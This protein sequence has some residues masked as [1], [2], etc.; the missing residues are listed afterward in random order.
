MNYESLTV[1]LAGF[2]PRRIT[3]TFFDSCKLM[4]IST[5]IIELL[6]NKHQAMPDDRSVINIHLQLDTWFNDIPQELLVW[7]RS[8]SPLPH[9]ITLHIYYWYLIICL[10]QPFYDQSSTTEGDGKA[11]SGSRRNTS[12]KASG[13]MHDRGVKMVDRA[14]HKIVQLLQMFEEQHSMTFFPRNM[15]HVIYECGIVLLKEAVMAPLTA[16][17]KRAT[18]LQAVS[19]CLRALRRTSKTW[20]WAE[21]LANQLEEDLNK[22][23]ANDTAQPFIPGENDQTGQTPYPPVQVWDPTGPGSSFEGGFMQHFSGMQIHPPGGVPSTSQLGLDL[24]L[25]QRHG[26]S[27]PATLD[28]LGGVGER[29]DIVNTEAGAHDAIPFAGTPSGSTAPYSLA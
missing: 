22:I 26:L 18:V 23:R 10:Y 17:K 12:G 27:D 11:D 20:P 15:I 7:A 25:H 19:A 1:V 14:T 3:K 16:T 8:T 9:M 28:N 4:V 2:P 13:S 24:S 6:Y 29:A 21:R 5:R